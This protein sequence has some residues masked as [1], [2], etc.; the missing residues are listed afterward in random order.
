[1]HRNYDFSEKVELAQQYQSIMVADIVN[2][3]LES[4]RSH[5]K[6]QKS[7]S[8]DHMKFVQWVASNSKTTREEFD[9]DEPIK[10]ENEASQMVEDDPRVFNTLMKSYQAILDTVGYEVTP[11]QS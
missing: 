10:A 6:K 4:I 5:Q 1:M 3:E 11:K 8:R 2:T 7:L 9:R